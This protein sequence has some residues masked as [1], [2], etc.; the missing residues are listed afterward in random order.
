M[1]NLF[2]CCIKEK[3]KRGYIICGN[4]Q[5]QTTSR[6]ILLIF[7]IYKFL[8]YIFPFIERMNDM[9]GIKLSKIQVLSYI[10]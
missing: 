7:L 1:S 6:Q 10:S 8:H 5:P 4:P 3:K 9:R 2:H